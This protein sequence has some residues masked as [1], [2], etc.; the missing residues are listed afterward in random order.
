MNM[1]LKV[2]SSVSTRTNIFSDYSIINDKIELPLSNTQPLDMKT[3]LSNDN[4]EMFSINILNIENKFIERIQLEKDVDHWAKRY[5]E[6]ISVLDSNLEKGEFKSLLKH[7]FT[8]YRLRDFLDTI[9]FISDEMDKKVIFYSLINILSKYP[10]IKKFSGCKSY[11][12]SPQG[13]VN[14]SII[15]KHK[16]YSSI[17]NLEFCADGKITFNTH[18]NEVNDFLLHGTF[19][20]PKKY[21][22]NKKFRLLL[23]LLDD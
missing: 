11:S 20:S 1:K 22:S 14:L 23:R 4:I 18:D 6:L 16:E 12:I 7:T 21:L 15:K 5:Q 9:N 2:N 8:K 17:L 13:F 10:Y 19:I 3:C